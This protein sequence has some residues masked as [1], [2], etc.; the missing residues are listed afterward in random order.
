MAHV[1]VQMSNTSSCLH[2]DFLTCWC[3]VETA[4]HKVVAVPFRQQSALRHDDAAGSSHPVVGI[5]YVS[6][7]LRIIGYLIMFAICA[8]SI[9]NMKIL[10]VQEPG[11]NALL[12]FLL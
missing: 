8:T 4:C 5:F 9:A 7:A 6:D 11:L 2:M 12:L 1:S 10:L 3:S